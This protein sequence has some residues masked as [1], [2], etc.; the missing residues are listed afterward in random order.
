M[1]LL[2]IQVAALGY[3][4]LQKHNALDRIEGLTFS[5]METVFPAVTC[6]AQA[7][8]RTRS[9]V[10][11]HGMAGNGFFHKD[12]MRP[13]FWEQSCK[14]VAGDRIW[15]SFREKGKTVGMLFWQ[16][17]LGEDVDILLSPAPIH[18]HHGGIIQS[19]Y[20]KPD[21]L[22]SR[23]R[24]EVGRDFDLKHYWGPMASEKSSDWIT[25]ATVAL[26]NDREMAPDLCFTYLPVLDYDLQRF[27]PGSPEA[28]AAL[29]ILFT[30]LEAVISAA[31]SNDYEIVVFGDYA[32]AK[33]DKGAILPNLLLKEAGLFNTRAIRKK[34]YPDFY[35]SSAFAIVDHEVAHIHTSDVESLTKARDLLASVTGIEQVLD[36]DQQKS[37]G[38]D[39]DRSGDLLI[40]A[41]DGYWFAYPWWDNG[42]EAPEF[43]SH[44][45]IHNKPGYDPCELFMGSWFPP[46]VSQ[47][48]SRI[49]G[50]HG[51][52]GKARQVAF[53]SSVE[54]PTP[55]TSLIDL[56]DGVMNLLENDN[57]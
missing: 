26:L 47:D 5:P 40:T 27:G 20:S 37:M 49:K 34:M 48:H 7:A 44:V 14:L 45:D 13:M 42:S 15:K 10:S 22:Y 57:G 29:E 1:K 41:C 55:T 38:I 36:R 2:V 31:R 12:L 16:Q 4:L 19:C 33:A 54:L 43:A 25:S 21:N 46:S 32:I 28:D 6:T 8:F 50:T 56:A 3:D 35:D 52:S 24:T 23:I 53:A 39:H 11:E 17:S 51:K 18:K 9:T 30:E